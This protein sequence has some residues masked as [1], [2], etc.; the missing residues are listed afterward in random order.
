[1]LTQSNRRLKVYLADLVY[2]TVKTNHVVPLNVAYIAAYI[3]NKYAN[4]I[5]ITIFKYPKE[6]EE[7]I[8]KLR[9]KV[10]EIESILDEQHVNGY[11]YDGQ[12]NLPQAQD[13]VY[14]YMIFKKKVNDANVPEETVVKKRIR[15]KRW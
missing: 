5:D 3:K 13:V 14:V 15:K 8:N 11:I 12:L 4:D 10:E 2:D 1:M 7:S 9:F 6:L